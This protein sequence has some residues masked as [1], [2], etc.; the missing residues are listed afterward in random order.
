MRLVAL[1]IDNKETSK[2]RVKALLALM[3]LHSSRFAARKTENGEIILYNDQDEGRWDQELIS[4][5]AILLHES[6]QGNELS[7]YHLE[8]SIAG[9][10]LKKLTRRKSGHRYFSFTI[11][12]W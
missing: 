7:K 8:A 4:K 11:N 3:C 2:P 1:V 9:G 10:K 5:G 6:S 12:C